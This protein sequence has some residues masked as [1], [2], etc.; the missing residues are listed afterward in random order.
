MPELL[1][2]ELANLRDVVDRFAVDAFAHVKIGGTRHPLSF[3]GGGPLPSHSR[4][5]MSVAPA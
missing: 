3:L 2:D 5:A 1:S 4:H